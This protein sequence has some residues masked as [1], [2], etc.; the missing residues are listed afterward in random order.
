MYIMSY[1]ECSTLFVDVDTK[2][3]FNNYSIYNN[4]LKLKFRQMMQVY[5]MACGATRK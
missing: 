3:N 4:L 1:I 2:H 5:I